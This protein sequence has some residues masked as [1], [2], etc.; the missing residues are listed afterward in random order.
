MTSFLG[1]A[2]LCMKIEG[3]GGSIEKTD[4]LA[5]F[6]SDLDEAELS[7]VPS[8]V[9]G[10]VFPA[11]SELLLGVGPSTL[12]DALARA[13]GSST[14]EIKDILRRTGDVGA[15]AAEVVGMRRPSNLSSFIGADSLSILDVHSRFLQIAR[16]SGKRSQGVKM[17]HLRY[18]FGEA[19]PLE[20][21]YIARIALE[22]MRIGVGEGIVRDAI[23]KAFAASPDEVE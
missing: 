18:L 16:A 10:S 4:L 8:F 2:E 3:I 20:A 19:G 11:S 22:D 7:V 23:A 21:R 9:T 1:F 14:K 17:K 12:Y 6:L 13:G 15:V 5:S